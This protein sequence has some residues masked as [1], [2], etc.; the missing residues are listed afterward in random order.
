[1]EIVQ[2]LFTYALGFTSKQNNIL[3]HKTGVAST[4]VVLVFLSVLSC[5]YK[6]SLTHI[7]FAVI[8]QPII[9]LAIA[10]SQSASCEI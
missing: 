7:F 1:M 10:Y 6:S 3:E 2:I 4:N 5:G 8:Y 9:L